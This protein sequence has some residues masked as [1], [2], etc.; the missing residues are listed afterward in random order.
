MCGDGIRLV[1]FSLSSDLELQ[2]RDRAK[3]T[4]AFPFE[5]PYRIESL[6]DPCLH[7]ECIRALSHWTWHWA[8]S[9]SHEVVRCTYLL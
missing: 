2:G 4:K 7:S 8:W 5:R 3:L 6:A 1:L 9:T